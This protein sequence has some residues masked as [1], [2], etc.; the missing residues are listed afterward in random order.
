MKSIEQLKNTLIKEN[1]LYTGVLKLAEEKTKVI[2]SRDIKALENITKK[3]Q[4]YIMNMATFEKL[5]RSILTNIAQELS[6]EEIS[7]VSELILFI[8]EDAGNEID[9]LRNDLLKTIADL[10]GVNE[11]NEKLIN[12][13]LQYINLNIEILTSSSE[14]GN[15]YSNKASENKQVKS[16]NFFDMKV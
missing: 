16:I 4:Q 5:R 1:E 6:I 2:V 3:E 9:D 7:S 11:G 15:R 10:K 14:D 8:E 13:S 12:Q